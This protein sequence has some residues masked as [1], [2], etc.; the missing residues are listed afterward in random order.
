MSARIDIP[1]EEIASFCQF[2]ERKVDLHTFEGVA[3]SRNWL[4]EEEI[5]SSAEA[6]YERT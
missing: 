3:R 5:L 4:L 1:K 2:L 6:V